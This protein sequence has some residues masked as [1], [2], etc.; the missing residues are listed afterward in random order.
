[1][2]VA[3]DYSQ[4]CYK[5]INTWLRGIPS[6]VDVASSQ[7]LSFSSNNDP[8][9]E[10]SSLRP[11]TLPPSK[12]L[13]FDSSPISGVL[14]RKYVDDTDD[15][16]EDE[17]RSLSLSEISSQ[18]PSLDVFRN[19][20][21]LRPKAPSKKASSA[22]SRSPSPTRKLLAQLENA[23]PAVKFH[24]P[25]NTVVQPE[26]V[27]TLRKL[28]AKDIEQKVIPRSLEVQFVLAM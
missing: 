2:T 23:T 27:A 4:S 14:K 6:T 10:P 11:Y 25:G 12:L 5:N 13:T 28:L 24:Y 1:M 21:I 18:S 3:I 8:F 7:I 26:Q 19:R 9:Q 20:P 17:V 16:M 15:F 22:G